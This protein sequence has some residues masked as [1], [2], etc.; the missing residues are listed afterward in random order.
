M[1]PKCSHPPEH[2]YIWWAYDCREPKGR[3]LCIACT[4]CHKILR[5]AA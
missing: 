2:L 3:I 5:G 4:L 1:K